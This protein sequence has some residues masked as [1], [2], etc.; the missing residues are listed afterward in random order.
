MIKFFLYLIDLDKFNYRLKNKKTKICY[1]NKIKK[2]VDSN[3][4]SDLVMQVF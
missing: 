4:Y 1:F 2:T 3:W